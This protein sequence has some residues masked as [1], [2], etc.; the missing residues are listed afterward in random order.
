M[1]KR[2]QVKYRCQTETNEKLKTKPTVLNQTESEAVA[3]G[4]RFI[5]LYD[6]ITGYTQKPFLSYIKDTFSREKQETLSDKT[7]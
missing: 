2:M 6:Y 5:K 3:F 4:L 7:K 1:F